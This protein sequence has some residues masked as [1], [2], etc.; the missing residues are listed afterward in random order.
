MTETAEFRIDKEFAPLLFGPRE[1]KEGVAVRTVKISLSDPRYSEVG[2]LDRELRATKDKPF[3]YGW[4]IR[5]TW[6]KD[7]WNRAEAALLRAPAF[8]P[9]GEECGTVYDESRA[10]TFCGSGAEQVSGLVLDLRKMPKNKHIA[11]TIADEVVVTQELAERL[12]DGGLTGFELGRVRHKARYQ[13]DA[14]DF[15]KLDSGREFIAMA[16]RSGAKFGTWEFTVWINRPD[17]REASDRV[18]EEYAARETEQAARFPSPLP[19]WYQLIIDNHSAKIVCPTLLGTEPFNEDPEG[20]H[21]CPLGHKAG[22]NVL[23]QLSIDRGS[24][25]DVDIQHTEQFLGT[26][27]G[28]LRPYRLMILSRKFLD[29]LRSV[30]S[31]GLTLEIVS[32]S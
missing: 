1:G 29:L 19:V 27:R 4:E 26:R 5:R 11:R 30:K 12:A 20:K 3:F 6:S 7:E 28:L 31:R 32:L 8:E 23:S 25:L 2:R 21:R 22:L 9:A 24:L 15:E 17:N 18:T 14:I 10:C 16:E 13:D